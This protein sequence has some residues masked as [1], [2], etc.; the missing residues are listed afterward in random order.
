M[1]QLLL[2][3]LLL[4]V[5]EAEVGV[6]TLVVVGRLAGIGLMLVFL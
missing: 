4:V 5:V 6:T 2:N 1:D 3:I